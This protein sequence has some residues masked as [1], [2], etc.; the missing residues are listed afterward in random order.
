ME[1]ILHWKSERLNE[2]TEG[3]IHW[4]GTECLIAGLFMSTFYPTATNTPFPCLHRPPCEANV[5]VWH[6]ISSTD[7]G[8]GIVCDLPSTWCSRVAKKLAYD[9][10]YV[11]GS[12]TQGV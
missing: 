7:L 8:P 10:T 12:S 9:E 1:E 11:R 5:R 3:G 6:P 4:A 2:M